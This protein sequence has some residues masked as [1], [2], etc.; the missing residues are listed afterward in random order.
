MEGRC[1]GRGGLAVTPDH[2]SRF[3]APS[4]TAGPADTRPATGSAH[5][6][7]VGIQVCRV[8]WRESTACFPAWV[9]RVAS[10]PIPMKR[11]P[12]WA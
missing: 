8:S 2:R 10:E 6:H 7:T 9:R 11:R 5:H 3:A 12:W 1:A 4:L